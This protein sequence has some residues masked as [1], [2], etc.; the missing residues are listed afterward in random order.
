MQTLGMG[1]LMP[2]TAVTWDNASK[3]LTLN[4]GGR[5][6]TVRKVSNDIFIDDGRGGGEVNVGKLTG[7][8]AAKKQQLI[9]WVNQ[10]IFM[11]ITALA[12]LPADEPTKTTDPARSTFYWSDSDGTPNPA[13]SFITAVHAKVTDFDDTLLANDDASGITLRR[14]N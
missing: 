2:I 8:P 5:L 13:G 7:N 6:A 14:V 3:T 4:I 1:G 12:D 10:F 11:Q 9:D